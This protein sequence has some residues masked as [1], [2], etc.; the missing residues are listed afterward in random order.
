MGFILAHFKTKPIAEL[1]RAVAECTERMKTLAPVAD[2]EVLKKQMS[3]FWTIAEKGLGAI[4]HSPHRK[5]LDQLIE[6]IERGD[7]LTDTELNQFDELVTELLE[8]KSTIINN[9]EKTAMILY[10]AAVMSRHLA[11]MRS[12]A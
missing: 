10:H 5:E 7:W 3:L 6:K 12:H 9:D 8:S 2:V 11:V 1:E 4:L